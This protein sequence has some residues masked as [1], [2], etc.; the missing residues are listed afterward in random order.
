MLIGVVVHAGNIQ[1]AHGAK[2][3]FQALQPQPQPQSQPQRRL[4][5][6]QTIWADGAYG[7]YGGE[8][9]R[10]VQENYGWELE[11]VEKPQSRRALW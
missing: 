1:D 10:W 11:I 5:R 6:M 4:E 9:I 2:L 3:V 8:L 7:M